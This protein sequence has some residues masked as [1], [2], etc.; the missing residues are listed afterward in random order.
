[1]NFPEDIVL[2]KHSVVEFFNHCAPTWD[3]EMIRNEDAITYILDH[4]G[5]RPGAAVL[6]VACGT[7]VL[8]P[9]YAARG[10]TDL[11]GIDIS[12]EMAKIAAK[13]FPEATMICGDVEEYVFDRKFDVVMVYNA[14]PHF[15]DPARLIERLAALTAPGGTLSIAH[16]MSKA[17]LD[18]HHSGC[19]QHVSIR[20]LDENDLAALLRPW[21]DVDVI[22]ADDSMYQV[23]G[24]RK[25]N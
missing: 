22:L 16:G 9:D 6:D 20:L 13:K 25:N 19:A 17:Q 8:F 14:F 2:E 24:R 15:P 12:P 21:F 7:G 18:R 5:V 1:M 4:A 23:T 11:T 10:V 3:A